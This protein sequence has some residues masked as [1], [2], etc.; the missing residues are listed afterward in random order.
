MA[1]RPLDRYGDGAGHRPSVDGPHGSDRV[2]QRGNHANRA[3]VDSILLR[4]E[5]AIRPRPTCDNRCSVGTPGTGPR[6]LRHHRLEECVQ[7]DRA[8]LRPKYN[9]D[10]GIRAARSTTSFTSAEYRAVLRL[11]DRSRV[12]DRALYESIQD[13]LGV[14]CRVEPIEATSFPNSAPSVVLIQPFGRRAN[15]A[16]ARDGPPCRTPGLFIVRTSCHRWKLETGRHSRSE[17]NSV[18][19]TASGPRNLREEVTLE[20]A[21]TSPL[22]ALSRSGRGHRRPVAQTESCEVVE[23]RSTRMVI[24]ATFAKSRFSGGAGRVRTGLAQLPGRAQPANAPR[25]ILRANRVM[26]AIPATRR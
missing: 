26:R 13:A 18:F 4:N 5:V 8:T 20:I 17:P 9:L 7:W 11:L 23:N 1:S 3:A 16:G 25:P 10:F 6:M 21:G 2:V 24:E 22:L 15:L 14:D 12:Q 19:R